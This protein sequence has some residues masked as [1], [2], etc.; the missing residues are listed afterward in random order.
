MP[1]CPY[2]TELVLVAWMRDK[3]SRHIIE[4][5]IAIVDIYDG[6]VPDW[7]HALANGNPNDI[8]AVVQVALADYEEA[9]HASDV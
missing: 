2:S 5:A 8:D 7:V 4:I 6:D 1:K 9:L 3:P